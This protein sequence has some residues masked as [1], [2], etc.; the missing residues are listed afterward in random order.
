MAQE[1][2]FREQ[3]LTLA[4]FSKRLLLSQ[5]L[6]NDSQMFCMFMVIFGIDQN[7]VNEDYDKLVQV[8]LKDSV[9]IV[10]KHS[11]SITQTKRHDK[12]FKVPITGSESIL[13]H[14]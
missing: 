7:V 3:K 4:E 8:R 2:H 6:Q 1:L 12:E 10:H 5:N 11:W 9:H 13:G 14:I